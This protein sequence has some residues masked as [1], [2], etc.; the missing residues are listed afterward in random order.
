[1][2]KEKRSPEEKAKAEKERREKRNAARRKKRAEARA[3][4]TK[5]TDSG[6]SEASPGPIGAGRA[7][8]GEKKSGPTEPRTRSKP[9]GR[10]S[11]PIKPTPANPLAGDDFERP[12]KSNRKTPAGNAGAMMHGAKP[13]LPM[14]PAQLEAIG[15]TLDRIADLE[16][17]LAPAKKKLESAKDNADRAKKAVDGLLADRKKLLEHLIEIRSGKWQLK[18]PL[19]G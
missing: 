19:G 2:A 16:L 18:L 4:K 8:S 15:E 3:E 6:T 14:T 9:S 7:K 11:T 13:H 5:T 12:P 17:D 10:D 1:M